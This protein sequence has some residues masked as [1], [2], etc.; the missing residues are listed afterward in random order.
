M[1]QSSTGIGLANAFMNHVTEWQLVQAYMRLFLKP[2]KDGD[3]RFV[4]L[5]H[6]GA[7]ELRMCEAS[8]GHLKEAFPLWLEL[9]SH[10]SR[11]AI[12]RCGCHEFG[13][14]AL[15]ADELISY[16]RDIDRRSMRG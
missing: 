6:I 15:I 7:F 16:A 2:E 3:S 9:Y 14:A 5:A 10:E 8:N 4:S 1:M 12:E 11:H 13:E